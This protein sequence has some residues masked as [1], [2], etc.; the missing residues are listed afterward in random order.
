ME[1]C[2]LDNITYVIYRGTR[3]AIVGFASLSYCAASMHILNTSKI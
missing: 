1:L 3:L 2:N